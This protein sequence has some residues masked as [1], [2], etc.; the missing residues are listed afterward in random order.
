MDLKLMYIESETNIK[1]D[2]GVSVHDLKF[3]EGSFF[4]IEDTLFLFLVK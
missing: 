3:E 4:I 1:I 2:K